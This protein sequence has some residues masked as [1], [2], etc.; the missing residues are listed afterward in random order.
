VKCEFKQRQQFKLPAPPASR[1][2]KNNE[3]QAVSKILKMHNHDMQ[4]LSFF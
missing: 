4:K 2:S 3:S 1:K